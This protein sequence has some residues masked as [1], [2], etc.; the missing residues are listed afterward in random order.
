L[1]FSYGEK[2]TGVSKNRL[3]TM[4]KLFNV[5][6]SNSK[7]HELMKVRILP[8]YF[9]VLLIIIIETFNLATFFEVP[10]MFDTTLHNRDF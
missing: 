8:S 10:H 9:Y 4:F 1:F 3:Q 7:V 6:I 5:N 2:R